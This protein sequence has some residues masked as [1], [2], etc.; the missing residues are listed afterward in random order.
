MSANVLLKQ[1]QLRNMKVHHGLIELLLPRWKR[2]GK[3]MVS[4]DAIVSYASGWEMCPDAVQIG[5]VIRVVPTNAATVKAVLEPGTE[6]AS[7][8]RSQP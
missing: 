7:F 2:G 4:Q 5:K 3:E 1:S 6:L 8:L